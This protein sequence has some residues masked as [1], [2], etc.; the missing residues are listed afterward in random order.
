M[1]Y[2]FNAHRAKNAAPQH[3]QALARQIFQKLTAVQRRWA[4]FMEQQSKKLSGTWLK[5]LSLTVLAVSGV[6]SAYLIC[7]G[8]LSLSHSHTPSSFHRLWPF[9][10]N[11]TKQKLRN[12]SGFQVY[13]DSLEKAVTNDSLNQLKQNR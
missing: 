10:P 8:V 13:L 6:Y 1:F 9:D 11:G 2:N 4:G 7:D 12:M 5:A 3:D